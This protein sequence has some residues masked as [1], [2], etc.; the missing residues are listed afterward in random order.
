MFTLRELL[1]AYDICATS[2]PE[3]GSDPCP[4]ENGLLCTEVPNM[5]LGMYEFPSSTDIGGTD[6]GAGSGGDSGSGSD[7]AAGGGD[8]GSGSDPVAGGGDSGSAPAPSCVSDANTMC[9]TVGSTSFGNKYFLD[10]VESKSVNLTPGQTYV[11][12]QNDSSNAGHPMSLSQTI[13][14]IHTAGGAVYSGVRYYIDN[15]EVSDFS[16]YVASFE[17]SGQR[18]IEITAP[19]LFHTEGDLQLYYFCNFHGNIS[20]NWGPSKFKWCNSQHPCSSSTTK[21]F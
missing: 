16:S 20:S 19:T 9:V 1:A 17:S 15:V 11:F 2:Q 8:S 5:S 13:K 18:R 7:P 6:S 21:K 4:S 3:A 12:N 10:G 14:G